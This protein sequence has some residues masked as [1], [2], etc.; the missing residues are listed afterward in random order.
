MEKT[1]TLGVIANDSNRPGLDVA[2]EALDAAAAAGTIVWNAARDRMAR[3]ADVSVATAGSPIIGNVDLPPALPIDENAS[4]PRADF[5]S[6]LEFPR[7][8]LYGADTELTIQKLTAHT[9]E[10]LVRALEAMARHA[11]DGVEEATIDALTALSLPAAQ[12]ATTI[13]SAL[14]KFSDLAT[15]KG[16]RVPPAASMVVSESLRVTAA[17]QRWSDAGLALTFSRFLA[18]GVV[19]L[20][21]QPRHGAV[22][23]PWMQ[24]LMTKI[25]PSLGAAAGFQVTCNGFAA[26]EPETR[27]GLIVRAVLP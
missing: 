21:P 12:T 16:G 26:A 5:E 13:R 7:L 14:Q 27:S 11:A 25:R 4:A 3:W 24:G 8:A 10:S 20:L 1:R 22:T 18:D 17:D 15:A 19:Y 2:R 9:P 6:D 23:M